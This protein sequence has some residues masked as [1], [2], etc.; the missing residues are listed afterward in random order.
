MKKALI[1]FVAVYQMYRP[2][3]SRRYAARIAFGVAFRGLPF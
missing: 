1:E 3:H 2:Q